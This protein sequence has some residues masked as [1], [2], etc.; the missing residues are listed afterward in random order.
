MASTASNVHPAV[1]AI[2]QQ[3]V[4][5]SR[6]AM[7]VDQVVEGQP[8]WAWAEEDLIDIASELLTNLSEMVPSFMLTSAERLVQHFLNNHGD[9]DA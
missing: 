9:A 5:E 1:H 8:I 4:L 7:Y 2:F 6:A 3:I